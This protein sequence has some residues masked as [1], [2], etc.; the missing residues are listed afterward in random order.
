MAS[1]KTCILQTL[2]SCSIDALNLLRTSNNAG[3][4]GL[5][6][7]EC[8][9]K[10][11]DDECLVDKAEFARLKA[12]VVEEEVARRNLALGGWGW[13]MAKHVLTEY[14]TLEAARLE[15]PNGQSIQLNKLHKAAE[16]EVPINEVSIYEDDVADAT[17]HDAMDVCG[18]CSFFISFAIPFSTFTMVEFIVYSLIH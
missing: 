15:E 6:A 13:N 10:Y 4:S 11:I 12:Y 16:R 2:K 7:L 5:D 1:M 14:P 18:A 17:D 8:K 9:L 3:C